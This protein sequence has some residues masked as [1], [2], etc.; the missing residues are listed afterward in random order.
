MLG[1]GIYWIINYA[2][3]VPFLEVPGVWFILGP[4]SFVLMLLSF[5]AVLATLMGIFTR[6]SIDR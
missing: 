4:P 1:G 6:R 2:I 5:A 3:I